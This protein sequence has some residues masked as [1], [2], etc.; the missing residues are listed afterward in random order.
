ME[1]SRFEATG[2][3]SGMNICALLSSWVIKLRTHHF[4][5]DTG[6]TRVTP[7][8]STARS[9][10][11]CICDIIHNNARRYNREFTQ[12]R[13]SCI[14]LLLVNCTGSTVTTSYSHPGT[15]AM[16]RIY[17]QPWHVPT[18][19]GH[20]KSQ[21]TAMLS[22]HELAVPLACHS[23]MGVCRPMHEPGGY[24]TSK[25]RYIVRTI[26]STNLLT[27][28]S[29]RDETVDLFYHGY[30]AYMTHA[31]PE[32][33]LKPLSC[34][35]LTR[36]PDDETHFDLNDALG[37][38]SLTLV[39]SL[40]T[41]AIFASSA[42]SFTAMRDPLRDFEDGIAHMVSLY[43]DGS[44]S[45]TGQGH[46]SR[47]FDLDSKVQVFETVI[48]GVGGLLSAHL[49][50]VG[51]LPIRNYKPFPTNVT[52]PE[53]HKNPIQFSNGFVYN[54][55]L[56]RLAHDLALRLL[57]AFYTPTG[58]PYP[59]VNLRH[60]VPH[61]PNSPVNQNAQNG[62]CSADRSKSKEIIETCSAG[63][64][65]LTLEFSL[66]SRLT[67][68]ERFETLAKTAFDAV[69]RRRSNIG[70]VG[71]A[72]DPE[73]GQWAMSYTGVGYRCLKCLSTLFS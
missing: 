18:T 68:D 9:T 6:L 30:D 4:C 66:L 7:R 72:I 37:N 22:I 46:R 25:V 31:F 41:L 73:T 33:E 1:K 17:R 19:M 49:F 42:R 57:P 26:L 12:I 55:Q 48:R 71:S 16:S 29:S 61:Y 58:L 59:R 35:P 32:D 69:W 27:S 28:C 51:E 44:Q 54:G 43:G 20:A 21:S 45:A 5:M 13:L 11:L 23:D 36:N 70:L 52:F 8:N 56:L 24:Q 60:G 67:G 3:R 62:Q 65:S 10:Q 40:S 39:D 50:A 14:C 15:V 47:G 63:A 2:V 38:Y 53:R 34:G 64:G